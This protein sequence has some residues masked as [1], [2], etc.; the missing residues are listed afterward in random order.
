MIN[1][2][3]KWIILATSSPSGGNA[4]P[5]KLDYNIQDDEI[6]INLSIDKEYQAKVSPMDLDGSAGLI[7]LGCF[8]KTL[9]L[10]ASLDQY[11][12]SQKI[13]HSE[14][15]FWSSNVTYIYKKNRENK[16]PLY[17]EESILKRR[18]NRE[19]YYK[20]EVPKALKNKIQNIYKKYPDVQYIEI[21][22]SDKNLISSWEGLE[23][24]RFR[25]KHLIR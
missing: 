23:K 16:I 1:I 21:S 7:A 19:P 4:Q 25:N 13:I 5:W 9:E 12:I 3:E 18:T 24:L 8:G 17:S 11:S 2:I 22:N 20:K 6:H 10:A 15:I 14:S